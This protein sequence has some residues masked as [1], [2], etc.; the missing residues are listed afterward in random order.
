MSNVQRPRGGKVHQAASNGQPMC[1]PNGRIVHYGR[2]VGRITSFE[3]TDRPV[4]CL[5][6]LAISS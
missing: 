5:R 2:N 1:Q 3:Q 4:D 6:C